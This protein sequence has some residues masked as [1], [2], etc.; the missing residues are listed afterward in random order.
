VS[1][2]PTGFSIGPVSIAP[3]TALAPMEGITDRPFRALIR[4][5]GGCGLTV[6]EFVPGAALCQGVA[7]A[8]HTAEVGADEHPVSVQ[9]YGRDPDAMA[10]AAVVCEQ[11]GADI[12]DLN[13]GCP[14]K[15]VTG[16]CSGSALMRE[17]ALARAIFAA[18]GA[19]LTVPM[20]V[21]M[22]L[23]WD[24]GCQNAP[25]IARMAEDAGAR[26]VAVHG[27]TRMQM[28]TG[29][30]DWAA[31]RAVR[32]AISIPVLVNGDI[33]TV[34]DACDAVGASGADGV[35]IG[36]GALRDPWL[37]RRVADHFAGRPAAA[38]TLAD[39]EAHL[40]TYFDLILAQAQEASGGR[41]T[42]RKPATVRALGRMK[43][44]A[45]YFTRGL[46]DGEALRADIYH[47]AEVEPVYDAVRRWFSALAARGQGEGAFCAIHGGGDERATDARRLERS[48]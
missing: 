27:R 11:L 16:G 4:R 1:T 43:K 32:E 42:E 6:T 3:A 8:W 40:L 22:R 14:S 28:Y 15:Q 10:R 12:V 41:R 19:A 31:V 5:L 13:L 33:L 24:H 21:K 20:T 44:V 9:I 37:L 36:R 39:R 30:A 35:M 2:L 17:P 45:G 47:A 29:V 7:R 34:Q 48:A 25:L 46:P 26:M 38:P 18:V 23:G